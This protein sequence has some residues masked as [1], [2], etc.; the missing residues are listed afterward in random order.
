MLKRRTCRSPLNTSYAWD[1]SHAFATL[2]HPYAQ[3]PSALT[4]YLKRKLQVQRAKRRSRSHQ[5]QVE[6]DAPLERNTEAVADGQAEADILCAE[7]C[8]ELEEYKRIQSK[9][10]ERRK[11]KIHDDVEQELSDFHKS[12]EAILV[13]Q[14]VQ[15]CHQQLDSV[16]QAFSNK[17]EFEFIRDHAVRLG[18]ISRD[19]VAKPAAKRSRAKP[20]SITVAQT[21][22]GVRSR[23]VSRSGESRKRDRSAS[24]PTLSKPTCNT[25]TPDPSRAQAMEEDTTPK[26]SPVVALPQ[27]QPAVTASIISSVPNRTLGTS[28]HAPGN[29]M[30]DDSSPV[31][32]PTPAV[33]ESFQNA[34]SNF[35]M[36]LSHR[37]QPLVNKV[38]HLSN[39][40]DGRTR[41]KHAMTTLPPPH[42]SILTLP[43]RSMDDRPAKRTTY[44]K[45]TSGGGDSGGRKGSS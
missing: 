37:L 41:P 42:S 13:E 25:S 24:P 40:V 9:E 39:M 30:V 29:E 18:I 10:L 38:E 26:A 17:A 12:T 8:A 1:I 16:L 4:E 34:M 7:D 21:V 33:D 32:A 2:Y 23:S 27:A 11:Q 19:D 5:A 3:S 43:M 6:P 28:M 36:T 35:F 22:A 15:Q 14:G 31:P 20:W 44:L 45:P